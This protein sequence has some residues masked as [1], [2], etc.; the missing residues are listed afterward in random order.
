MLITSLPALPPHFEVARNPI[1]LDRLRDRLAMLHE[2]DTAVLERLLDFFD[3][4]RQPLN[5]TD[6]EFIDH[7]ERLKPTIDNRLIRQIVDDRM[8]IRT[9]ISGLRLR[10]SGADP[11]T[12]PEPWA[13]DIKRSWTHPDFQLQNRHPWVSQFRELTEAGDVLEAERL[14]L[15]VS[16]KYWSQLATRYHFTFESVILYLARWEII[17]R[18]TSR[19]AAKGRERFEQLIAE[20]LG[21]HGKLIH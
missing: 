6:E 19:D 3:W 7:F 2:Q 21:E 15:S 16:W 11:P 9:I 8:E 10:K 20:T 18:W 13:I 14:Q 17:D 4:D 1:P 5:R 12:G